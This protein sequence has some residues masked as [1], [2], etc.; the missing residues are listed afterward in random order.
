MKTKG[1]LATTRDPSPRGGRWK[2]SWAKW[3]RLLVVLAPPLAVQAQFQYESS[4]GMMVITRYVGS[5]K[6]VVI[7]STINGLPVVAIG[8]LAFY[9]KSNVTSVVI[10][11]SVTAIDTSAFE[12]CSGLASVRIPDSVTRIEW[13]AFANCTSLPTIT[14]GSSLTT[15]GNEAFRG[16]AS[17]A[18][19]TIP[20]GVNSIG[21]W[22][23]VYC[24]NLAA[25][26]VDA[27]NVAYSSVDG[28]LYDKDQTTLIQCPGGKAGSYAVPQGVANITEWSL[29]QC[30]RLT[31]FTIP[32]S[33]TNIGNGAFSGCT[34]LAS[35]TIGGGLTG[36]GLAA[37]SACTR[38]TNMT[39]PS[40]VANFGDFV[41]AYCTNLDGVYFE[42][43]APSI[44]ANYQVFGVN[45]KAIAY[46]MPGTLGWGTTFS[47]RPAVLWNPQ[48][49][50]SDASF[51]VRNNQFGF[52]ITGTSGLVIVVEACSDL[53]HPIWSVVGTNILIDGSS[54]FT[55]PNWTN[56]P[57]RFYRLRS[58]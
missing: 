43:N 12:R 16:C 31:R 14:L 17:L 18:N 37:F 45:S 2:S 3:L 23:F 1:F 36:I 48:I 30:T 49:L 39:I 8:S 22:P 57:A 33:V 42:G 35:V 11:D 13:S 29:I 55:D 44:G 9:E 28:V 51:G 25:I 38:L 32:D 26:E 15:I 56:V 20:A 5:E 41:F 54:Y 4:A 40:S 46:Y 27:S 7:P 58:P 19:V 34:N 52:T 21:Y 53:A 24:D 50:A 6:D 47:G 10:P